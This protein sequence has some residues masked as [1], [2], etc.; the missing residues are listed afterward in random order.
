MNKIEMHKKYRYR[1]GEA[2]R[3]LCVDRQ[4]SPYPV[5]SLSSE[6]VMYHLQTGR[7]S[8]DL[9]R[10][11]DYDLIEVTLADTLERGQPF[12]FFDS[13][14]FFS[15]VDE[16]FVT[17]FLT[18]APLANTSKS[19]IRLDIFERNARLLTDEEMAAYVAN[20]WMPKP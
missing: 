3:V 9:A 6:S 4:N 20:T 10:K 11:T 18:K 12:I 8:L 13:A 14:F 2:A 16:E 19:T 15:K 5:I 17:Y 1:N 7:C